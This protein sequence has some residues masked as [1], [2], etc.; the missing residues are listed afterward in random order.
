MVS[1]DYDRRTASAGWS[2][3]PIPGPPGSGYKTQNGRAELRPLPGKRKQWVL[4][5]DGKEH[6][7]ASK[8]PGF[9]HA[10]FIL[11]RELGDDYAS[12]RA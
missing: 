5:L 10:E 7:I 12:R 8:K 6:E 1:Y 11:R 4:D 3:R 9:G 2:W